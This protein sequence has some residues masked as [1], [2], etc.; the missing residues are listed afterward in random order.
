LANENRLLT[1]SLV[2]CNLDSTSAAMEEGGLGTI[3]ESSMGSVQG[4]ESGLSTDRTLTTTS[5]TNETCLLTASLVQSNLESTMVE[6]LAATRLANKARL[7][8]AS[9]VSPLTTR[10]VN[11]TRLLTANL[12]QSRRQARARWQRVVW[13]RC[14]GVVRVRCRCRRVVCRRRVI[15]L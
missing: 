4:K 5:W 10:S 14:R 3:E 15:R 8:T 6:D 11:K 9:L 12:V 1:A 2:Q 7:L 13:E